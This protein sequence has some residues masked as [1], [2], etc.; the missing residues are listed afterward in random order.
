MFLKFI[1]IQIFHPLLPILIN[2]IIKKTVYLVPQIT[3]DSSFLYEKS[4]VERGLLVHLQL[5]RL[6]QNKLHQHT[7]R[8]AVYLLTYSSYSCFFKSGSSTH[9]KNLDIRLFHNRKIVPK[10][11][12]Y[13][14]QKFPRF[15]WIYSHRTQN[16]QLP[17][18]AIRILH[19]F[20]KRIVM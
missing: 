9:G 14:I 16:I 19:F 10:I 1:F 13:S 3:K 6:Y 4:G 7:L 17:T 12:S 20:K 11:I 8:Y 18:K 5:Q 2:L 15:Y